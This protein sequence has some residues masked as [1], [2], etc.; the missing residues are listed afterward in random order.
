PYGELS[1]AERQAYPDIL[2]PFTIAGPDEGQLIGARTVVPFNGSGDWICTHPD[3][4]IFAETG[5]TK[6]ERIPGLV[7]W[8][9]HGAPADIAG[10]EVVG[11]GN[12]LSWG[13]TPGR[14]AAT[15]YPG[16][17]GNFVFNA[18]T[19]WWAQG[20]SSPP[21]HMLP[22]SHWSRPHGPDDRVQ[23]ITHNL[24]RRAIG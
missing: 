2:G 13:T 12:I 22:W 17:R 23:Q 9:F 20:L 3:H 6:G 1:D 19:I 14:W 7:G 11:E 24:I 4:W 10:L 5:M 16:P 21:G 18:S 8:E 15:I